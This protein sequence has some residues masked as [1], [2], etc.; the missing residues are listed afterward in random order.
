METIICISR[1]DYENIFFATL[2]IQ[3]FLKFFFDIKQC[4]D[5]EKNVTSCSFSMKVFPSAANL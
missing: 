1:V 2:E 3:L 4:K 5:L